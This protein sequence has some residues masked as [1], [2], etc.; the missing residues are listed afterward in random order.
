MAK[1]AR[2]AAQQQAVREE[3]ERKEKDRADLL[4]RM[5]KYKPR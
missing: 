1:Y 2:R 3:T 5:E 4:D